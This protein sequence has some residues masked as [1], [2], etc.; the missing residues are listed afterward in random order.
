MRL[1][2]G[3]TWVCLVHLVS[4]NVGA[5]TK[6][7]SRLEELFIWR[8][9]DTL[10]LSPDIESKF[11][12]EFKKLSEKKAALGKEI[13]ETLV[14]IEKSKDSPKIETL[15]TTYKKKVVEQSKI[16]VEEV[17]TFERL[18]GKQKF[19]QYLVLKRDLT[20]KLK[21]FVSS[22]SSGSSKGESDSAKKLNTP[23]IIQDESN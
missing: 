1:W 3:L 10:S 18:F 22:P 7:K 21:D 4:I 5:S 12:A 13:E 11:S 14:E 8:V 20:Q 15:L 23:K 9:S 19:A 6:N 2:R 16:S 17:E